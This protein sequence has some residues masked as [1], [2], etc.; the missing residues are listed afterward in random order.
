[1]NYKKNKKGLYAYSGTDSEAL[2][3]LTAFKEVFGVDLLP[4]L[5]NTPI[6]SA[7]GD[8]LRAFEENADDILPEVGTNNRQQIIDSGALPLLFKINGQTGSLIGYIY[9]LKNWY[10]NKITTG[11]VV[12][13]AASFGSP[14]KYIY[15][16]DT[17]Y[18]PAQKTAMFEKQFASDYLAL[19]G[20][21][22]DKTEASI[23]AWENLI[24]RQATFYEQTYYKGFW[25]DYMAWYKFIRATT[26][27]T[28]IVK[29]IGDVSLENPLD[30]IAT[31]RVQTPQEMLE[32][33]ALAFIYEIQKYSPLGW[34]NLDYWYKNL[35]AKKKE[36][37][38]EVFNF[39][40]DYWLKKLNAE[41]LTFSPQD[42]EKEKERYKLINGYIFEKPKTPAK[43]Y[44]LFAT[45]LRAIFKKK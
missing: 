9:E 7:L 35:M 39:A 14:A 12:F 42:K 10:S 23:T 41:Y 28:V 25:A 29:Q 32:T 43:K 19:G 27:R 6:S 3:F 20:I 8:S 38:K 34:A 13:S 26:N 11:K 31:D 36:V 22:A 30:K 44:G 18:T 21:K 1:M 40:Y 33:D 2:Q 24:N 37:S 17:V 16:A 15:M 45:I 4:Y 5:G